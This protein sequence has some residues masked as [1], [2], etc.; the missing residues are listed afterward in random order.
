MFHAAILLYRGL[1]GKVTY[2]KNSKNSSFATL[3]QMFF[4][5]INI[6]NNDNKINSISN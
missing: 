6:I 5:R 2:F 4:Y 1:Q 3:P